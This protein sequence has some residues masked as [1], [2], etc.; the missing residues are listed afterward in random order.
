MRVDLSEVHKLAM[1]KCTQSEAAASLGISLPSFRKLL[2]THE[3][4]KEVWETG[5][6]EANISLRRKQFNL[7]STSAPMAIH[8]GKHFLGQ[9]D[10]TIH[11]HTGPE[12]EPLDLSGMDKHD[13]DTIRKLLEGAS[14][15]G[16]G[17]S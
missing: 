9:S 14:F 17:Q 13:R 10:K 15:S 7:A 1:L 11:E 4:F 3:R 16:T 12:G 8:L 5:L 6:E 2:K